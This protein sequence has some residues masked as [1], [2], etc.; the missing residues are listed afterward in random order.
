MDDVSSTIYTIHQG[1]LRN[2][3]RLISISEF[4]SSLRDS[5]FRCRFLIFSGSF[6]VNIKLIFSCNFRWNVIECKFAWY[7]LFLQFNSSC[8][9]T[10]LNLM[11]RP[12]W[13]IGYFYWKYEIFNAKRWNIFREPILLCFLKIRIPLKKTCTIVP[14]EIPFSKNSYYTETSRLITLQISW[15]VSIWYNF[16]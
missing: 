7:F 3:L 16:W 14:S 5:N 1:F 2:C 8:L 12:T 13:P 15:P 9:K 4:S 11:L 10:I 6:S